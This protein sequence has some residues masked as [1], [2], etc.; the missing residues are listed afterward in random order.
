M[1]SFL[2]VPGSCYLCRASLCN[3]LGCVLHGPAVAITTPNIRWSYLLKSLRLPAAATRET[4]W[5]GLFHLK[6]LLA[7]SPLART[8]SGWV[9]VIRV[10]CR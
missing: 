2:E 5:Q 1:F 8:S 7:C 3:L 6:G 9:F 10:P 4:L